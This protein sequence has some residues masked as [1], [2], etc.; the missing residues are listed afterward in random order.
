M[1]LVL[2][3]PL[4]F[5]HLVDAQRPERRWTKDIPAA[6]FY[7]SNIDAL[8]VLDDTIQIIDCT[9]TEN[10]TLA[11]IVKVVF[12]NRRERHARSA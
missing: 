4:Q 8:C 2:L 10:L 11:E 6:N 3:N 7:M 9:R 5:F 12:E 1:K